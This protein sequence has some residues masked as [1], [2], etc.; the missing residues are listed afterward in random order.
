M[1][2]SKLKSLMYPCEEKQTII[3]L[4]LAIE[5]KRENKIPSLGSS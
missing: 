1:N 4:L 5:A 2:Y 3:I